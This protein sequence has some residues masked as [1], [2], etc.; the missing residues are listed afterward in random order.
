TMVCH[1][2]ELTLNATVQGGVMDHAGNT[3]GIVKWYYAY[4]NGT[5]QSISLGGTNVHYTPELAGYYQF[6][7]RYEG[8]LGS[9]C[10]LSDHTT[11]VTVN[12]RPTATFTSGDGMTICSNDYQ[13]IA[14]LVITLTG[15]APFSFIVKNE[16]TGEYQTIN[17]N[18][19][20]YTYS[21]VPDRTSIYR[22]IYLKDAN[23]C[24]AVVSDLD[25]AIVN[26]SNIQFTEG[27]YAT[28]CGESDENGN[29]VVRI[30]FTVISGT[31]GTFTAEYLN[32]DY[33][34]FNFSGDV[35]GNAE[36]GYYLEFSAPQTPGNYAVRIKIDECS[37]DITVRT[38]FSNQFAT[39]QYGKNIIEQR[40][41]DVVVVNNN[42]DGYK[43]VSYQ[44]YRN[45]EMIPGATGQYYQEVGGLSGF[46]SV[47]LI[48]QDLATGNMIEYMTCD[49]ASADTKAVKVYPV[50]AKTYQEITIELDL[51]EEELNGALLDIFDMKGGLVQRINSVQPVTKVSGF[52]AQGTYFGRILTGTNEIKTVKFIIVK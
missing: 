27:I 23:G 26:V 22:I 9:G 44:W 51:T 32:T 3:N 39:A 45:G 30:P 40:W 33:S 17:T 2:E 41:D 18:L 49:F 12:P 21:V 11:Q 25:A 34:V 6:I 19:T 1:G 5:A 29:A 24:E 7:A 35:A 43:F 38:L 47:R 10:N 15:R 8:Q 13:Q 20:T 42:I 31:A 50:P 37:Y 52:V 28:E 46:Y 16:T 48:A 36:S 14:H 4:E